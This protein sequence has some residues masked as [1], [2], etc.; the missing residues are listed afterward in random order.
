MAES[1][2]SR[3]RGLDRFGWP[4]R[5]AGATTAPGGAGSWSDGMAMEL[6]SGVRDLEP[7][8]FVADEDMS[9]GTDTG[10]IVER[11]GRKADPSTKDAGHHASADC[12]EI[13]A[14]AGRFLAHRRDIG[15]DQRFA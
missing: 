6:R 7:R 2:N 8:R 13:A 5:C 11:A 12:A 15:L 4:S 1:A 14:I 10:V 9:L 3:T